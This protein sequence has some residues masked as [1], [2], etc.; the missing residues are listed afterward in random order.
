MVNKGEPDAW[1]GRREKVCS[2]RTLGRRT[3]R[4]RKNS[5]QGGDAPQPADQEAAR[6]RTHAARST[7]PRASPCSLCGAQRAVRLRRRP[8]RTIAYRTL[9]ALPLPEDVA[10]PSCYRCKAEFLE[11]PAREVLAPLLVRLYAAELR[12]RIQEA[13]AVL[14]PLVSQRRLE[15]HLGL[16]QGYLSRLKAGAGTPSPLLV[17]LLQQLA[18]D[19]I[20]RLREIERIWGDPIPSEPSE[21]IAT[22]ARALRIKPRRSPPLCT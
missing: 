16:S 13:I 8:G 1:A 11:Q 4:S 15:N 9:P 20:S 19:P 2:L 5:N 10:L 18:L 6:L 14:A 22:P 7:R 3:M 21:G 12:R 17:L